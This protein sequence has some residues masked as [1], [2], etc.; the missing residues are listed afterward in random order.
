MDWKFPSMETPSTDQTESVESPESSAQAERRATRDWKFPVMTEDDEELD[1]TTHDTETPSHTIR[2]PHAVTSE[3]DFTHANNLSLDSTTASR[4]STAT[5][6]VSTTSDYDPFRFDRITS[7]GLPNLT[8]TPEYAEYQKSILEG[9]GPDEEEEDTEEDESTTTD[10]QSAPNTAMSVGED[11]PTSPS[12]VAPNKAMSVGEVGPTSPSTVAP[13]SA[14]PSSAR[15]TR[16]PI[17]FPEIRPPSV[18]SLMAGADDATVTAEL[19]RLLDAFN[20]ALNSTIE[21]V[22]TRDTGRPRHSSDE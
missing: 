9:P 14:A 2:P 19:D 1:V 8:E 10:D 17:P 22:Q 7:P 5:S 16:R 18:E 4:P 12:T 15:N 13:L 3:L 21:A 20:F 6:T 11:A